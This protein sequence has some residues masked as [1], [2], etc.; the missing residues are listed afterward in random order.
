MSDRLSG[1]LPNYGKHSA[2][3]L[4]RVRI[5]GKDYYLGEYGSPE[6]YERYDRLIAE[7]LASGRR[8]PDACLEAG[9]PVFL[10]VNEVLLAFWKYAETYYVKNGKTTKELV[11]FKYSILP[12][13]ELYGHTPAVQ[14]GR[15]L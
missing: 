7:Y 8:S 2:R 5:Q 1:S 10:T 11:A 4:A 13:K 14:F 9:Q 3:N 6:S 15:S 12:V